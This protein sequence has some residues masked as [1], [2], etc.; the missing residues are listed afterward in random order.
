MPIISR[1][2][3]VVIDVLD[4]YIVGKIFIAALHHLLYFLFVLLVL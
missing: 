1:L 3:L 4:R 2:L